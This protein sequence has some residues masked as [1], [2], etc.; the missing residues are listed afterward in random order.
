MEEGD[1]SSS[2]L[3][4]LSTPLLKLTSLRKLLNLDG[5][6]VYLKYEGYNPT[7]THKDRAALAHV[8][9]AVLNG[10]DTVTVGTCG[11]YG[12]AVA[13]Y[14]RLAGLRAV[15]FVPKGYSNS[16]VPEMKRYGARVVEVE[17]PYE[18]AVAV[19]VSSARANGWYDANPGS[20]NDHVSIEAYSLIAREIVRQLGDAP[21]VVA[22]PVGNGTTL[23]GIY[24]G[25]YRL[26]RAGET[27]RIPRMV[28]AST[29]NANQ[30]VYSWSRGSTEPLPVEVSEVRE[31]PVNE[32]LVAIRSLNAEEALRAIYASKGAAFGFSDSEMVEMSILLR[33]FEGV[34]ALPASASALLAVREYLKANEVDGPVV[35]VITGR[36]RR[37]KR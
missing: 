27:T 13:Y 16:R 32:P 17:G 6:A 1:S 24:H 15:I 33:A 21:A 30:L 5:A 36:W 23:V 11:N 25:F 34:S 19:S 2:K 35:A 14:A 4:A 7:G 8:G 31:T 3:L 26:Y 28:A 20:V 9:E 12:V 10:Y 18:D 29:S 37:E 22:V